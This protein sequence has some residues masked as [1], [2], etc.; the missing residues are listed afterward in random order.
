MRM[1]RDE[2]LSAVFDFVA[3]ECDEHIKAGRMDLAQQCLD[4]LNEIISI[5]T[6]W[7]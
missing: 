4:D 1:A 3:E 6:R 5:K 7:F 2:S